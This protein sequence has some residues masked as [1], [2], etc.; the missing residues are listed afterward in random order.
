[1]C[2]AY[3]AVNKLKPPCVRFERD[4]AIDARELVFEFSDSAWKLTFA[5]RFG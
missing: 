4:E 2:S 5:T 1:V 3:F